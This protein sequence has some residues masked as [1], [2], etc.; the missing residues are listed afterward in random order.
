MRLLHLEVD[1]DFSE[2]IAV[3]VQENNFIYEWASSSETFLTKLTTE[4]VSILVIDENISNILNNVSVKN[5]VSKNFIWPPIIVISSQ[6]DPLI[7]KKCFEMGIMG[8]F[9][10]ENFNSHRFT[11]YL[12]TI[13]NE[14]H[15]INLIR[16]LKISV[17]DDSKFTLG[18]L[19]MFF[20]AHN[21]LNVNYY[22]DP[23][24]F[25]KHNMTSNLF[26]IDL[27]LPNYDGDDIIEY[28]REQ[29]KHAII[30]LITSHTNENILM[31]Y[32]SLGANDF[33]LKPFEMRIFMAR[34]SSCINNYYLNEEIEKK[35]E[36]LL[37]MASRD[38]LTSLYN[39]A[40][41]FKVA[42]DNL[43]RDIKA[44]C[45]VSYILADIDHFKTVND[46]YGHL[47]GDYVLSEIARLLREKLR[48]TD[49]IGR[50]GGEEF[51]VQIN[52][53]DA[54]EAKLIAEKLRLCIARHKFQDMEQV[55]ISMGV[56]Q[57]K[58]TDNRESL[59]RRLD[60]S[61]YLAKLTGRNKVVVD[62]MLD[63][64]H[65][66]TPLKIE[67]GL[68]F[69]S[70][71]R[72]VD[73]EHKTLIDMSNEIIALSTDNANRDKIGEI[74]AALAQEI[75]DH[76]AHEIVILRKYNYKHWREHEQIHNNLV[77]KTL[78]FLEL[79]KQHQLEPAD[80]ARYLVQEV[81][82]GHIIRHDFNFFNLFVSQ[83][84]K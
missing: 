18:M 36:Q 62:A 37:T 68:F 45:D 31:H 16:K 81:V 43:K 23:A 41:F 53:T 17:L 60:D 80:V 7:K 5:I 4:D 52:D 11:K 20:K 25:L 8:Y 84:S 42:N 3:L 33:I 10:K 21:I 48:K 2:K 24:D 75:K 12:K 47:K 13:K 27:F 61:L 72:A 73:E 15:T 1:K 76:F 67:W 74:F 35:N 50:W 59:F 77:D 70:G 54:D 57:M 22:Q 9:E 14:Y 55:T 19:R 63:L 66:G 51:I 78:A 79:Y 38:A 32:L 56:S 29:N 49:I 28:I 6:K 65:N 34:L 44:K 58:E 39:R 69:M 30:I 26:L 83:D 40:Y 71:N 82:I 46:R 64:P